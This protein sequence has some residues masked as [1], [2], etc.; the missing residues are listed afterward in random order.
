MLLSTVDFQM[1]TFTDSLC[2][3]NMIYSINIWWC[4]LLVIRMK[5]LIG[6]RDMLRRECQELSSHLDE[7]KSPIVFCHNDLMCKNMIFS[8]ET[9]I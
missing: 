6:S 9:G 4:L 5:Q 2:G 3:V 8:K 1:L 7:L